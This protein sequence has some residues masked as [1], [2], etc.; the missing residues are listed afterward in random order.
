MA[1]RNR[2]ESRLLGAAV[3]I[4]LLAGAACSGAPGA[5]TPS[6]R[7]KVHPEVLRAAE[8]DPSSL[9]PLI[10]REASPRSDAAEQLVEGLGGTVTH[11]LSIIGSFSAKLPGA[12]LDSLLVSPHVVKVWGDGRIQMLDEDDILDDGTEKYDR[13]SPNRVW[14]KAIRLAD[15][16]PYDGSG[17]TV[18]M[19]DTGILPVPDLAG[20][21]LA[22]AD[23]TPEGDGL[24]RY[25]HGTHMAGIIAGN[26]SS[27][28]G[29]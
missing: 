22:S 24:D 8:A 1:R 20:R 15:A 6:D 16:R 3:G 19:L 10:V 14:Q 21:I 12:R 27:S 13:A 4:A 26:G 7:T 2:V 23:F 9:L 18:A 28:A 11:D 5:T 17:V 25:G 29:T